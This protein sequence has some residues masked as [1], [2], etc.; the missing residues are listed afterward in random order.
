M[1]KAKAKKK[2]SPEYKLVR[3]RNERWAVIGKD[4]KYVN[5]EEKVK[6][7]IE[8]GKFKVAPPKKKAA[9]SAEEAAPPAEEA[10]AE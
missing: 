6:I 10:A 8:A 3:K 2:A 1:A 7:L 9:P 4:G 5:G